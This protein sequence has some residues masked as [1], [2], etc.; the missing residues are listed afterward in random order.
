M[1]GIPPRSSIQPNATA[2][3]SEIPSLSRCFCQKPGCGAGWLFASPSMVSPDTTNLDTGAK[4]APAFA[5]ARWRVPAAAVVEFRLMEEG[6]SARV[7]LAVGDFYRGRRQPS[8]GR[9]DAIGRER[10]GGALSFRGRRRKRTS[11]CGFS[12]SDPREEQDRVAVRGRAAARRRIAPFA[13]RFRG[14][15]RLSG[16]TPPPYPLARA[17]TRTDASWSPSPRGSEPRSPKRDSHRKVGPF[18][19]HLTL[20]AHQAASARRA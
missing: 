4:P 1:R 14:A 9:S 2:M 5:V 3:T 8:R 7:F 16:R 19:P 15:R 13:A 18:A 6:R 12:G 10:P 20:G 17:Q 11:P